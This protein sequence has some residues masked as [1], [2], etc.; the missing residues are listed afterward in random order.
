MSEPAAPDLQSVMNL[1]ATERRLFA[2]QRN[3][4][5][6]CGDRDSFLFLL[7]IACAGTL[8]VSFMYAEFAHFLVDLYGRVERLSENWYLATYR[9]ASVLVWEVGWFL[10]VTANPWSALTMLFFMGVWSTVQENLSRRI[11]RR[12]HFLAAALLT[13]AFG[14]VAF[15]AFHLQL[16]PL[17]MWRLDQ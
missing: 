12:I 3:P 13:L 1:P 4:G 16:L 5:I 6:D 7:V 17:G 14:A 10:T 15:S 9:R 8:G 11:A 2:T